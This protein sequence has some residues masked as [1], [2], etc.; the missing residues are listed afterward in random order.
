MT[1]GFLAKCGL[2]RRY[3]TQ[4]LAEDQRTHMIKS[5]RWT[6]TGSNTYRCNA[7]GGFHAG[8]L[9]AANRGKGRR[10]STRPIFHTQ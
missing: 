7:C 9:G 2:K 10:I 4:T 1:A 6:K 3:E 5:G 8:R